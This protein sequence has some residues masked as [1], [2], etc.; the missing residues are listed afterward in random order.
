M[1]L[2]AFVRKISLAGNSVNVGMRLPPRALLNNW[3]L[4]HPM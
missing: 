1:S 4:V 2:P 3:T